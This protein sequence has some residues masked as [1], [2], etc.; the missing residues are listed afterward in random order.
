MEDFKDSIVVP[1]SIFSTFVVAANV[2]VCFL[3]YSQRRMRT[4]C[5]GFVVSLAISDI[6]IG[7]AMFIQYNLELQNISRDVVN[8]M[9]SFVFFCGAFNLCAVTYERYLAVMK[10]FKYKTIIAKVFKTSAALIWLLSL[11]L[12][13]LPLTW[14]TRRDVNSRRLIHNIYILSSLGVLVFCYGFILVS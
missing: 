5:N 1:L 4:Y 10:P 14:R 7:V 3:V 12:S 6:M 2:L 11:L 13:A 9:Y 8:L